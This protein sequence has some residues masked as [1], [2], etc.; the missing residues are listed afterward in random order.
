VHPNLGVGS[1]LLFAIFLDVLIHL[2]RECKL[3]VDVAGIGVVG[4]W[5]DREVLLSLPLED[6]L[7]P[8]RVVASILD[9]LVQRA[10]LVLVSVAILGEPLHQ[11][12]PLQE[13]V[14]HQGEGQSP[15]VADVF[16]PDRALQASGSSSGCA[17]NLQWTWLVLLSDRSVKGKTCARENNGEKRGS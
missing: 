3:V 12:I 17:A 10:C 11:F 9:L 2:I 16:S 8:W 5:A 15:V 1:F 13:V 6:A 4:V 7:A 14:G